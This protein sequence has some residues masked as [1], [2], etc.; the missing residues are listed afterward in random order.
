MLKEINFPEMM[1]KMKTVK[2]DM[3]HKVAEFSQKIKKK[4]GVNDL[5]SFEKI[6]V[7]KLDRFLGDN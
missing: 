5:F 7:D 1:E 3:D 6:M 4:V 2:E